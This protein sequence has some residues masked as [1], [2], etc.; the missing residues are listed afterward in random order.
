MRSH[1][2]VRV[3]MFICPD[4]HVTGVLCTRHFVFIPLWHP[5]AWVA[6][7]F[8]SFLGIF[9]L[10]VSACMCLCMS[11][12]SGP[13]SP[14]D[15]TSIFCQRFFLILATELIVLADLSVWLHLI[16]VLFPLR[17]HR[18]RRFNLLFSPKSPSLSQP[19]SR[20]WENI[21]FFSAFF[22]LQ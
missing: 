2:N 5:E 15:K 16:T 4:C 17:H 20:F 13:G 18:C 19:T 12:I 1:K 3:N 7:H 11:S 6:S 21:K 22:M 10:C 14:Q 9:I 8:I